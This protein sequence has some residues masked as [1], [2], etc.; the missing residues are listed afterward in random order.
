MPTLPYAHKVITVPG[1][2]QIVQKKLCMECM[3]PNFFSRYLVLERIVGLTPA[4]YIYKYKYKAAYERHYS[5]V[6]QW[7]HINPCQSGY[8]VTDQT[9]LVLACEAIPKGYTCF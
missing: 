7:I 4:S 3:L 9:L 8:E 6:N 2:L 1:P 5:Q